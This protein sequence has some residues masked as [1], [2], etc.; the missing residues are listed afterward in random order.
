MYL[1]LDSRLDIVIFW[2]CVSFIIAMGLFPPHVD[3]TY[4]ILHDGD[5]R[6]VSEEI[7]YRFLGATPDQEVN[8]YTRTEISYGRLLMQWFLVLLVGTAYQYFTSSNE[9]EGTP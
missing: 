6:M 8:F 7:A 9:N 4:Q 1:S 3:K 2:S 5:S